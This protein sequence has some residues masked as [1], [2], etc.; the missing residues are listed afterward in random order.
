MLTIYQV[1]SD[2]SLFIESDYLWQ[3]F[4]K[5]TKKAFLEDRKNNAISSLRNILKVGDIVYTTVKTVSSSG[6]SRKI[7]CYIVQDG[8]I[9]S[10]SNLT[11]NALEWSTGDNSGSVTVT[12]CGMD[13]GFHLVYTLSS[14]LF[15]DSYAL[16]QEWI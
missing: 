1:S 16:K 13:M 10:I 14:V 15:G 5:I 6:M 3:G 9:R 11:G 2:G 8:K 12:G 4:T 7:S